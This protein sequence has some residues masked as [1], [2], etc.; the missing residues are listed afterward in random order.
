MARNE[1]MELVFFNLEK[2]WMSETAVKKSDVNLS[3]SGCHVLG[4]DDGVRTSSIY[5]DVFDISKYAG[6]S[7]TQLTSGKWSMVSR[8][9]V[10][11]DTKAFQSQSCL[12]A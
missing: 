2:A 9:D 7:D 8:I 1:H 5:L 10:R 12:T 11:L 4:T 6:I 3:A